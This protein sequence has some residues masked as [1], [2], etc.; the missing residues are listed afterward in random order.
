MFEIAA[1]AAECNLPI[2][3]HTGLGQLRGTQAI[4]LCDLIEQNP[5]VQFDLFH[6]SFPWTDD[7]LALAHKFL[8]VSIDLC[9]LPILST[10]RA[11][12]FIKEALEVT[13]ARRLVWGCDTWTSEESLGALM[14]ARHCLADALTDLV[15]DQR[16]D[17][18]YGVWL[19]ERILQHNAKDLFRLYRSE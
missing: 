4:G 10:S 1:C 2:Q 7:V 17:L 18:A 6:A 5:D 8:N 12:S 9:W 13:D 19:G 11:T 3:M 14:A 15:L 16:F